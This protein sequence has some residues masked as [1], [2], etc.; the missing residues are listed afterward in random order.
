MS[1]LLGYSE[2]K[3]M[4]T[5]EDLQKTAEE[6]NEKRFTH[7]EMLRQSI[8]NF[9]EHYRHS[10]A[11][12]DPMFRGHNGQQEKIVTLGINDNGVFRE[13][14]LHEL[15]LSDDFSL[16]FH[17]RT[18]ITTKDPQSTWVT[19][20]ITV[21]RQSEVVTFAFTDDTETISCRIPQGNLLSVYDEA[22]D[23]LKLLILNL[24]KQMAPE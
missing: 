2:T 22:V 24:I 15:K 8:R 14:Y 21:S 4:I 5:Y 7:A 18:I 9:I 6:A 1:V 17:I 3:T 23:T 16:S 12:A 19:S 10:L 13:K 11:I 20:P